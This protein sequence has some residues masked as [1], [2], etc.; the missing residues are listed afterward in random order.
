MDYLAAIYKGSLM[1][2]SC[3]SV[4]VFVDS[5]QLL[6]FFSNSSRLCEKTDDL[7]KRVY[8]GCQR[9]DHLAL[10]I[11]CQY[12]LIDLTDLIFSFVQVSFG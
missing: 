1:D 10:L 11:G 9:V 2:N 5:H 4:S 6:L 8:I 12:S 7:T 3:W